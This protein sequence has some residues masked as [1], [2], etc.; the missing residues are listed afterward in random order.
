MKNMKDMKGVTTKG[1]TA[2]RKAAASKEMG[3]AKV[4]AD[5]PMK[6]AMGGAAKK[7]LGC[8]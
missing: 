7:R 6:K 5:K 2:T 8:K 4:S 3:G 1:A